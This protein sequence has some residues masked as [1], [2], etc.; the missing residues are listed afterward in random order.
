MGGILV[1]TKMT[2]FCVYFKLEGGGRRRVVLCEQLI[3]PSSPHHLV[4]IGTEAMRGVIGLLVETT[5]EAFIALPDGKI[6]RMLNL[7]MLVVPDKTLP[8]CR[9]QA[10]QH[11][12]EVNLDG[13]HA[14][15]VSYG[16]YTRALDVSGPVL[17]DHF[18]HTATPRIQNIAKT[19]ADALL[20]LRHHIASNES[21]ACDA[22]LR[23]KATRLH[24]QQTMPTTYEPGNLV[25]FNIFTS[26]VPHHAR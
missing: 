17:H 6:S 15:H 20:S 10:Q 13:I 18:N 22:C 1:A 9:V 8:T 16:G 14:S 23:A 24:S 19:L 7:G 2:D 21:K 3:V 5:G 11:E 12:V 26:E 4:S 25:S